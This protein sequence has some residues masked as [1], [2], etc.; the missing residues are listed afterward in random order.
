MVLTSDF[1]I[2]EE[3]AVLTPAKLTATDTWVLTQ[4]RPTSSDFSMPTLQVLLTPALNIFQT[5]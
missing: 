4:D 2:A 3:Q 1:S 5:I